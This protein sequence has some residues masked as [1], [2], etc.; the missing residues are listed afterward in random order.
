M[1]SALPQLAWIFRCL[2]PGEHKR[3]RIRAGCDPEPR[4]RNSSH[5]GL[6]PGRVRQ[7]FG[8]WVTEFQ[9]KPDYG[10]RLV[11]HSADAEPPYFDQAGQGLGRT[12]Q[13]PPV[14]CLDMSAI[15]GHKPG[16]W[17]EAL[18]GGV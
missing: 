16:E 2:Q 7:S 18:R 9:D 6:P 10:Q 11:R 5:F 3:Q 14:P 17:D 8:L 12:H 15:V 13:Q 4:Q 1:A